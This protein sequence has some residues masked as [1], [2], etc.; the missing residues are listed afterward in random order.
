MET[1]TT[2]A[3]YLFNF[4]KK[5]YRNLV[6]K[7]FYYGIPL[8]FGLYYGS[9]WKYTCIKCESSDNDNN[10]LD[11]FDPLT[12]P[13]FKGALIQK[14]INFDFTEITKPTVLLEIGLISLP[15]LF[16]GIGSYTV[17]IRT[18]TDWNKKRFFDLMNVSLNTV[19]RTPIYNENNI[20]NGYKYSIY[21]RT[22]METEAKNII[23][24]TK[25]INDL[26]SAAKKA[27]DDNPIIYLK[28]ND[29]HWIVSNQIAN[30]ISSL[31]AVNFIHRD[32]VL[33]HQMVNKQVS[34]NIFHIL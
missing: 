17:F 26:I 19:L 4:Y 30:K 32:I 11:P 29:S 24:N 23:S 16:A 8:S 22:L 7:T 21:F 9:Q 18:R 27:N 10:N 31:C 33:H 5:M 20:I 25:G 1:Q 14:M 6:G 34:I 15:L 28:D 12:T 2:E 13:S 3:E